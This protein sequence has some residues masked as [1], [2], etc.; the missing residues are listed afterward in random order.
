MIL[1]D[2]GAMVALVDGS[3]EHHARCVAALKELREPMAT[4]WPAVSEALDRLVDVRAGQDAVLEM[5]RRGAVRLVALAPEDVARIQQLRD[6]YGK[7][8]MDLADASLVCVA[9]REGWDR[10]FT[11]DW[12]DF[13]AYR[14]GRRKAFRCVPE[15]PGSRRSNARVARKPRTVRSRRGRPGTR[16]NG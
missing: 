9:E 3:D 15:R 6:R 1:L 8:L 11:V 4:V 5:L 10:V 14:V 13:E 12:R 2:A 16:G 7:R